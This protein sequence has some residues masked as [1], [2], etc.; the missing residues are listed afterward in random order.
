MKDF[1]ITISILFVVAA[2]AILC[3]FLVSWFFD[4]PRGGGDGE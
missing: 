4:K 2:A 1:I 3:T